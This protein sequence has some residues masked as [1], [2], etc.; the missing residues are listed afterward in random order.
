MEDDGQTPAGA[1]DGRTMG[2][3]QIPA[4]VDDG[5]LLAFRRDDEPCPGS[6]G[7]DVA[8]FQHVLAQKVC[9]R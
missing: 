4:L 1:D 5:L 8:V 7:T 2:E 9:I 3:G 6:D